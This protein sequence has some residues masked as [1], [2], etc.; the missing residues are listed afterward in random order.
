MLNLKNLPVGV[1]TPC[2]LKN[3]C[4]TKWE[5][6][7]DHPQVERVPYEIH[8]QLRNQHNLTNDQISKMGRIGNNIFGSP[9]YIMES[10]GNIFVVEENYFNDFYEIPSQEEKHDT[11][12]R[13][14]NNHKKTKTEASTETPNPTDHLHDAAG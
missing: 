4:V 7:G 13:K 5:K 14:S 9:S 12:S 6:H 10:A 3:L 8:A 1:A 2:M 11:K